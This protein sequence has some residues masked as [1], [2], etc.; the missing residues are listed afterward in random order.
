M[1]NSNYK[2]H[3]QFLPSYIENFQTSEGT[4]DK[5]NELQQLKSINEQ[6]VKLL[7]QQISTDTDQLLQAATQE[8]IDILEQNLKT[9]EDES[10]KVLIEQQAAAQQAAAQQAA[11]QQAVA[12]QVAAQ[13]AAAQQ[14]AAQQVAAQQVAAQQAENTIAGIVYNNENET[15]RRLTYLVKEIDNLKKQQ[16]DLTNE[17]SKIWA[18]QQKFQREKR[19]NT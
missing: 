11:A 12:Q 3:R 5:L 10:S 13:Q 15:D 4:Q 6:G 9:L 18:L 1:D 14:A 19:K 8:Q 17:T 2:I 16:D 7:Q